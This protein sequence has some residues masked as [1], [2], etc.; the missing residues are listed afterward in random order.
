MHQR[1][2]ATREEDVKSSPHKAR[3]LDLR[4]GKPWSINT[5]PRS[6]AYRGTPRSQTAKRAQPTHRHSGY[7]GWV[8]N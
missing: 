3:L 6:T 8:R 5:Q 2:I 7:A 1:G 4:P